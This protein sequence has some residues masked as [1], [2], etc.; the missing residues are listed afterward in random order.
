MIT[1]SFQQN[2][3][4]IFEDGKC[5]VDISN[6]EVKVQIKDVHESDSY[7]NMLL[8]QQKIIYYTII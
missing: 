2:V 6:S 3:S 7:V 5:I 8:Y 4:C 1:L